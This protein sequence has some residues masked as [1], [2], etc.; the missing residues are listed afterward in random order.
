MTLENNDIDKMQRELAILMTNSVE[1][2][3]KM[4]DIF[5]NPTPADVE[6]RV[7]TDEGF[8]TFSVPNLAKSR[9][10][11]M[12]GSGS[13]I[14]VVA[15]SL[16]TIYIDTDSEYIYINTGRNQDEQGLSATGWVK[17]ATTDDI[18]IH[19]TSDLAHLGVLAKINGAPDTPFYVA[20]T[21]STS[22][23]N[24]AV[25]VGSLDAIIGHTKLLQTTDNNSV[26]EAIN[27]LLYT[28]EKEVGVIVDANL[29]RVKDTQKPKIFRV[30]A[31]NDSVG[32]FSLIMDSGLT[33]FTAIKANGT[34]YHCDRARDIAARKNLTGSKI[35]VFLKDLDKD[36]PSFECVIDG[37]YHIGETKP[38]IMKEG[39]VWLDTG[40]RPYKMYQEIKEDDTYKEVEVDYIYLGAIE[41]M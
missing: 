31:S 23:T 19:N 34:K 40:C 1:L 24:L 37:E 2:Q 9:I 36:V 18:E 20:D 5:V 14:G 27:E 8:E 4:Y 38:Y 13:P 30:V 3:N 17:I 22:E 28:A 6:L 12:D 26:I 32:S 7:W 33:S 16:G 10:P 35:L 21:D 15:G 29:N 41:E 11:V 25:N 39:D